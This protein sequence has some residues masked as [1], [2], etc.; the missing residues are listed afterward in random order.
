MELWQKNIILIFGIVAFINFLR[1]FYQCRAKKNPFGKT[2]FNVIFG[3]FVW[4]DMVIFGVFWVVVSTVALLLDDWLLFLLILSL[5]WLVRS[6]G[7]TAYWISQQFSQIKRNPISNFKYARRLFHDDSV[8][9]VYQI[10]WQ[11][12]TVITIITS[13]YLTRLWLQ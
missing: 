9:F 1:S 8:W 13:I 11:C 2:Y 6:I 12:I 3:A 10:F 4:A 5:F 7:E